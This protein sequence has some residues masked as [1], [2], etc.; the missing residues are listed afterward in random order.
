MILGKCTRGSNKF[1]YWEAQVIRSLSII[2]L[3]PT[4]IF[5][6]KTCILY[7]VIDARKLIQTYVLDAMRLYSPQKYHTKV[8]VLYVISANVE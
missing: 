6:F 5:K 7:D 4:R 3:Q 8:D 1:Y 2:V